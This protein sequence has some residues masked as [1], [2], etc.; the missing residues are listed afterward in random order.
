MTPH[1]TAVAKQFLGCVKL[2][3]QQDPYLGDL[4]VFRVALRELETGCT[5]QQALGRIIQDADKITNNTYRSHLMS[6]WKCCEAH[7]AIL[8]VATAR[9]VLDDMDI[10]NILYHLEAMDLG[11]AERMY[12][13]AYAGMDPQVENMIIMMLGCMAHDQRYCPEC[14]H[15][16][17]G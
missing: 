11:M 1:Q 3:I 15:H 14:M 9:N 16:D 7:A 6:Q 4:S 8:R 12:A 10:Q 13:R 17:P 5:A 2:Q